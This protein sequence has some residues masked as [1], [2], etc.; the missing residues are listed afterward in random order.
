MLAPI[1]L[2][3]SFANYAFLRYLGGDKATE[4]SQERRYSVSSQQKHSDLQKYRQEKNSFWPNLAQEI[5]NS[6]LWTVLGAGAAGALIE[7][8]M[9][10]FL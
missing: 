8:A 9:S 6:W 3:G 2:L 10:S 1:E 7:Q 4:F 5:N